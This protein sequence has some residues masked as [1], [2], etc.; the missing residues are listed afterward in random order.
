MKF[1]SLALA[2]AATLALAGSAEARGR[3]GG[4]FHGGCHN[5]CWQQ[6]A[7]T[8]CFQGCTPSQ[9][10]VVVTQTAQPAHPAPVVNYGRDNTP[11]GTVYYFPVQQQGCFNG[12]CGGFHFFRR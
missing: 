12:Q 6:P 3:C 9:G 1:A 5:T 8:T 2:L 11:A 10:V 4:R 7:C